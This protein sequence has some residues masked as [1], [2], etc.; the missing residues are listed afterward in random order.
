MPKDN[1]TTDENN[2]MIEEGI[3][4]TRDAVDDAID[5]VTPTGMQSEEQFTVD[6]T[7]PCVSE[8]S[9]YSDKLCG[10]GSL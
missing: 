4:N 5:R 7:M 1:G 8:Y 6:D 10:F 3:D 9:Q 2:N